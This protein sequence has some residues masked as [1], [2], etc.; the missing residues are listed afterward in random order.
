VRRPRQIPWG[1]APASER[2]VWRAPLW[3]PPAARG[4]GGAAAGALYLARSARA[5][6]PAPLID[7]YQRMCDAGA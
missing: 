3:G 7:A 5:V 2:H 1:H 4:A 6:P